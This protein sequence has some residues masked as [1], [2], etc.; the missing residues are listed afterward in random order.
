VDLTDTLEIIQEKIFQ[1]QKRGGLNHPVS[2]IAV[3]KTHPGKIIEKIYACGINQIGENRVQE[4]AEKFST[5]PELTSLKKHLIGH[6]QK[7]KVNK[8]I[9]LFDSIDLQKKIQKKAATQN[10]S[11]PVLLEINTSGEKAKFGF[12]PNDIEAMIRCCAMKYIYVR[13]LMTLGP[14]TREQKQ[15]RKAFATLRAVL[16][17]LNTQIPTGVRPC[18]ELSMGMSGDYEVAIEEGSTT[19]RLGTAL[20]GPRRKHW[21]E[22]AG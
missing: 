12:A 21:K 16:G 15:T 4:S 17:V 7:N 20:F 2:I 1:A 13:G 9:E 22:S 18:T 5:L 19:V 6:L 11:I 8:A 14:R 10:T 3:T